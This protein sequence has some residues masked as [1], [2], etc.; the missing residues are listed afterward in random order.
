MAVPPI[1]HG[2]GVGFRSGDRHAVVPVPEMTKGFDG[3][4]GMS[5][6]WLGPLAQ[7][8][9]VLLLVSIVGVIGTA[10]YVSQQPA[11]R[12]ETKAINFLKGQEMVQNESKFATEPMSWAVLGF[13][14]IGIG[15]GVAR[16]WARREK[17]RLD[18]ELERIGIFP[19]PSQSF[20]SRLFGRS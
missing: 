18:R 8:S 19:P 4:E 15:S 5:K 3:V 14:V 20:L 2:R 13:S 6:V 10:Y 9:M 12:S 11:V 16:E 7:L 1:D 17:K